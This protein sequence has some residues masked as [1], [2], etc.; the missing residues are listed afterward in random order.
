[1]EHLDNDMDD[2]FQ[3]AGELYPL[4]ISG[5]D[6]ETVAAKLQDQN[7][8]DLNAVTGLSANGTGKKRRWRLLLLLI[9]LGLAGL[10]FTTGKLNRHPGSSET[11]TSKINPAGRA[12]EI[13]SNPA[14]NEEQTNSAPVKPSTENKTIKEDKKLNSERPGQPAYA[15]SKTGDVKNLDRTRNPVAFDNREK[16]GKNPSDTNYSSNTDNLSNTESANE[17]TAG[18]VAAPFISS[19]ETAPAKRDSATNSESAAPEKSKPVAQEN[20][21]KKKTSGTDSKSFKGFYA[22][23]LIG[24]DWSTVKFQSVNQLGF[25]LGAIVGYRFNKHLA[26]ETG[27]LWDKKYY[28]TKGEYFKNPQIY[29]PANINIDGNCNMLEIPVNIRYDFASEKN[30]SFFAKAGLS[31]YV[32]MK[33]NYSWVSPNNY[34]VYKSYN[35]PSNI[36]SILHLSA[37]YERAISSKIN[38][39]VEPYVKIPLRGVGTGSMPISSV[40]I[41][42]GITHSFR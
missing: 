4:K 1:M 12:E 10:V 41:Y 34:P 40:G 26:V 30:H 23:L 9:P 32:A 19:N 37:G 36:F 25:S 2:L 14:V 29:I 18:I 28:H 39:Q 7:F 6:W 15:K 16:P 35:A 11:N 42:F 3:K 20:S 8:E 24:P 13:K 5:S 31:S 38:V 27:L 33:D 22:G 17:T 21:L